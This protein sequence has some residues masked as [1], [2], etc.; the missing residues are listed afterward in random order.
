MSPVRTALGFSW[1]FPFPFHVTCPLILGR[2]LSTT[3]S[4]SSRCADPWGKLYRIRCQKWG[5][6]LFGPV[7]APLFVKRAQTSNNLTELVAA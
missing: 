5:S 4:A 2:L 3:A 7:V 6:S 1:E